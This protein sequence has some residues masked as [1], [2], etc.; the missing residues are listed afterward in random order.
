METRYPTLSKARAHLPEV[1]DAAE[2]DLPLHLERREVGFAVVTESLLRGVLTG[3]VS[4]PTPEVYSENEGW[5]IVLP[6]TPVA[7]DATLFDEA[8]DDFVHA[9]VEY[10]EDWINDSDLRTA[11]SH[12][13]NVGLVQ[14]ISRLSEE[15]TRQWVIQSSPVPATAQ[16]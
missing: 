7:A 15:E 6:G 12:R 16:R 9:L 1:F 8:I 5:T 14:L 4:V 13:A 10:V 11:P 3:A 2:A